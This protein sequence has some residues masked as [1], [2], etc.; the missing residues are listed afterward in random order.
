[1]KYFSYAITS[2]ILCFFTIELWAQPI[3]HWETV[4]FDDDDWRY[5]VGDPSIGNDWYLPSYNDTNW[6]VGQGGFG[7]G[8]ADDNTNL[9]QITSIFIRKNFEIIDIDAIQKF[10]FDADF[11][12]GFVAYLNG[13]EIARVN[14]VPEFPAYDY[15]TPI[16]IEAQ[17]Y[18]GGLPE[19]FT[20]NQS[21]IE[22]MLLQGDNV[23][24][25]QVHNVAQTSSD[26]TGRFFLSL[27]ISNASNEYS[28]TPDWFYAPVPFL[29]NLPILKIT[30]DGQ[31]IPD[32][33]KVDAQLGIIYNGDGVLNNSDDLP[34]EF[35]G[36]IGIE[37]RGQSS[38]TFFEKFNYS[39]EFRDEEGE[40]IDTS[41]L[42][43]PK[44]SDWVLHGP[45][46]DKT[47]LRNDLMM[48]TARSIG[49]YASRTR[50]CELII[51]EEYLGVYLILE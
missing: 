44:E 3:D 37:L 36:K 12:D 29:S 4:V 42:N 28:P 5:K 1:M 27:G 15:L 48:W 10:I 16:E 7:Y 47:L 40:D 13:V 46:S 39:F 11:D 8:D 50:F 35:D 17:L 2:L 22:P 19:R 41:F 31:G 43:F 9:L 6:D 51:D 26:L 30:T 18:Q 45:Y 33:P 24:A 20:F 25:V 21:E 49:Q 38:Q 32:E 14:V 34:N 23:L